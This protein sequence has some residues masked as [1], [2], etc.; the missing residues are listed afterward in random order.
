MLFLA[1]C[2]NFDHTRIIIIAIT[3][4]IT[5][6]IVITIVIIRIIIL[7]LRQVIKYQIT[8]VYNLGKKLLMNES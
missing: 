1:S 3:N 7:L 5:I 8:V 6:T 2:C 4:I